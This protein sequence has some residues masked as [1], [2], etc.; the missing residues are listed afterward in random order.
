MKIIR[1]LLHKFRERGFLWGDIAPRNMIYVGKKQMLYILDFEKPL[2]IRD[3]LVN[4][5]DFNLFFRGYAYEEIS[6]VLVAEEQSFLFADF[7]EI[8]MGRIIPLSEI[9]SGRKRRTLEYLFG[10]KDC[11]DVAEV[12]LV[13]DVMS[14]VATPTMYENRLICPM[15]IIEKAVKRRGTDA[16]IEFVKRREL[17]YGQLLLAPRTIS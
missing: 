3:T 16:Y 14:A 8:D 10:N 2:E 9:R 6:C 11:Y 7:L 4:I 17:Y 1:E 15:P 12:A 5:L 13:E